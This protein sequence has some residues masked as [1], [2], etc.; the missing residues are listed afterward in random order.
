MYLIYIWW[1]FQKMAQGR[2]NQ[3]FI[4]NPSGILDETGCQ[5]SPFCQGLPLRYRNGYWHQSVKITIRYK[6]QFGSHQWIQ[7]TLWHWSA[8]RNLWWYAAQYI[9]HGSTK[10]P[11]TQKKCSRD[12]IFLACAKCA[13]LLHSLFFVEY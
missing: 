9:A 1:F 5:T 12:I 4:G 13:K 7:S 2:I 10:K 6:L 11:K 8:Q 3:L